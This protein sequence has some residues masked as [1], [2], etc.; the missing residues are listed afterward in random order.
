MRRC[1]FFLL[2]TPVLFQ[3]GCASFSRQGGAVT[4]LPESI[5]SPADLPCDRAPRYFS[6]NRGKLVSH[7]HSDSSRIPADYPIWELQNRDRLPIGFSTFIEKEVCTDSTCKRVKVWL[8]WDRVGNYTGLSTPCSQPLTKSDHTAFDR[9]DYE[10][11]DLI[12]KDTSSV[13]RRLEYRDLTGNDPGAV[14]PGNSSASGIDGISGAT[15]PALHDVVVKDAVYTCYT[16]W[17]TLYGHYSPQIRSIVSNRAN[18]LFLR[19]LFQSGVPSYQAWAIQYVS[20][21]SPGYPEFTKT[22][23]R[24]IETSSPDIVTLALG[25]FTKDNMNGNTLKLLTGTIKN[26]DADTQSEVLEKLAETE[27]LETKAVAALLKM[28]ETG[29]IDVTLLHSVYMLVRPV[30]LRDDSVLSILNRLMLSENNY[31]KNLTRRLL[32]PAN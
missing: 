22:I 6:E 28:Y 25:Y 16:L 32:Q 17:H 9:E 29:V 10:Q 30:H 1:I 8:F 23:C 11:L 13:L 21:K 19:Q 2:L 5:I 26:I 14:S 27:A 3:T 20:G 7:S 18:R 15:S 4:V 31:I 24:L 12:L